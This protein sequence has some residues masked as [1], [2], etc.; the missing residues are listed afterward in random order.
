MN[1]SK[2]KTENLDAFRDYLFKKKYKINLSKTDEKFIEVK[3]NSSNLFL[4]LYKEKL[5]KQ[6]GISGTRIRGF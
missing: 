1:K 3:N 6:Y 5:L 2:I 4:S